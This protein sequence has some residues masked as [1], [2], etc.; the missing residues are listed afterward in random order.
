MLA[1]AFVTVM[2]AFEYL[3]RFGSVFTRTGESVRLRDE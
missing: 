2:S 3:T 1:A